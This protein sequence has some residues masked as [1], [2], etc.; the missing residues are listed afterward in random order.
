MCIRDSGYLS[1]FVLLLFRCPKRSFQAFRN[2]AQHLIVWRSVYRWIIR[3]KD[4]IQEFSSQKARSATST[5]ASLKVV[6]DLKLSREILIE[7]EFAMQFS[8]LQ[9][10][11]ENRDFQPMQN[12][13][14]LTSFNN[15]RTNGSGFPLHSF[16]SIPEWRDFQEQ[17]NWER[18]ARA[19]RM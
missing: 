5:L 14:L 19:K 12:Y 17:S 7:S 18:N 2:P 6:W 13:P 1:R 3:F 15:H 9:K 11:I 16:G 10:Q 8:D 4:S